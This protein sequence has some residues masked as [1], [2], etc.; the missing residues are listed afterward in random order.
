MRLLVVFI[1][2][3]CSNRSTCFSLHSYNV[4]VNLNLSLLA[5]K[6][7]EQTKKL[8]KKNEYWHEKSFFFLNQYKRQAL[9]KSK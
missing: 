4:R 2:L 1:Q 7:E 3:P 5:T 8:L 9:I 6:N